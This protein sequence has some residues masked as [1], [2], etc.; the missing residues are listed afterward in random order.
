MTDA[1]FLM[2]AHDAFDL[3]E[4]Q[5]NRAPDE[6]LDPEE[7]AFLLPVM[8]CSAAAMNP[9]NTEAALGIQWG[10]YALE[11]T[12]HPAAICSTPHG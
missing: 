9:E 8:G 4:E 12:P 3:I 1:E 5:F 10:E 6:S 7:A 11:H 2:R